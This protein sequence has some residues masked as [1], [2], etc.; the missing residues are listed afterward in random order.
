MKWLGIMLTAA[1]LAVAPGYGSAEP[2]GKESTPPATQPKGPE[3]KEEQA[4][5]SVKKYTPKEKEAYQKK[6]AADLTELQQ[7]IEELKVKGRSAPQQ[8]KR[9]ILRGTRDL[10]VKANA[11]RNKL[12]ALEKAPEKDWGGLKAEMDKA[13]E[14]LRKAYQEVESRVK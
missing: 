8:M 7:K 4:P 1:L 5:K 2:P 13:M 14:E 9:M 6:T 12:G 3:K 11:A 10:Q